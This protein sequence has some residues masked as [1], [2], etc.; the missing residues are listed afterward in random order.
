MF[1]YAFQDLAKRPEVDLYPQALRAEINEV[2]NVL[3]P[4][5]Q[6]GVYTAGFAGDDDTHDK[7]RVTLYEALDDAERRL[8]KKTASS[9]NKMWL[10]E[11]TTFTM[12]DL[13]AFCHHFRFDAI[14]HFLFLRGRGK[15]LE[16]D[17]PLLAAHVKRIYDDVPGVAATCDLHCAVVG[18]AILPSLHKTLTPENAPAVFRDSKWSWYPS[19]KELLPNRKAHGLPPDYPLGYCTGYTGEDLKQSS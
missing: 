18:Y 11:G 15:T 2:N 17:Y 7:A 19:L 10:C 13:W 14:Y 1:N 12:A 9:S 6:N 4:G 5:V 8:A 16:K 3:Y